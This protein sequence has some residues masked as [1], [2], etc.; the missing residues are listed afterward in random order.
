MLIQSMKIYFLKG[1][2]NFKVNFLL[3]ILRKF[4]HV[5]QVCKNGVKLA[6]I[7]LD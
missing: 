3:Q 2:S 1:L 5:N 7:V 4:F 6:L